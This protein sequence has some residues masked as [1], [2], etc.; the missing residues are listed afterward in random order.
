M[1]NRQA[2]RLARRIERDDSRVTVTGYRRWPFTDRHGNEYGARWEI[3]CVDT[4]TGYPFVIS[5]PEQWEERREDAA[6]WREFYH[7]E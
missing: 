6:F 7:A 4:R 3:D 2:H 1:N 5:T